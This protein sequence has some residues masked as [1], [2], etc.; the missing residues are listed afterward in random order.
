M[1]RNI[2]ADTKRGLLH[3]DV[4]EFEKMCAKTDPESWVVFE[5]AITPDAKPQS[6]PVVASA[7]M[8][9]VPVGA[10]V[11]PRAAADAFGVSSSGESRGWVALRRHEPGKDPESH[12][13]GYA[14]TDATLPAAGSKLTALRL[15]PVWRE[16]LPPGPNP[17]DKLQGRLAAGGCVRVLSTRQGPNR[18]WAEVMPINCT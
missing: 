14:I 4:A 7:T 2:P 13:D 16:P 10:T 18:V 9:A 12:F 6:A 1:E 8:P 15:V 17:P 5:A 11:L 3:K